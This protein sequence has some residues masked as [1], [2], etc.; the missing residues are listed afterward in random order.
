MIAYLPSIRTVTINMTKFPGPVTARWFDPSNGT[1]SSITGSP[2]P[3]TGTRS[4][5]P[6]GNNSDGNGDW[7]L[8]L[9]STPTP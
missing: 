8:V 7:V 9:E 4:F 3:N 2:L 5:G 1:Y 6:S